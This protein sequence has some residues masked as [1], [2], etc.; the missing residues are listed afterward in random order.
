MYEQDNTHAPLIQV[1]NLIVAML[2][3]KN[4]FLM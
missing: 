3:K 4:T 1:A 2:I